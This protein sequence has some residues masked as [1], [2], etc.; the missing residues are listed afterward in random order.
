MQF[1]QVAGQM[2]EGML[3]DMMA[4]QLAQGDGNGEAMPQQDGGMPGQM[5]GFEFLGEEVGPVEAAVRE[6]EEEIR[7][8]FEVGDG[9][10]EDEEDEEED[11]EEEEEEEEISVSFSFVEYA[12]L[13]SNSPFSQCPVF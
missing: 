11:E 1:A 7:F 8:E 2:P 13:C 6:L 12:M 3:E 5:P 9:D 4:M 10:E